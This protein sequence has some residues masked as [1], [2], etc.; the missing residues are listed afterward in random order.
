MALP[1]LAHKWREIKV[2]G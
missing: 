2:R 1:R